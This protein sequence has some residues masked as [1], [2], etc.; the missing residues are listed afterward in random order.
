M[1]TVDLAVKHGLGIL[2]RKKKKVVVDECKEL[3]NLRTKVKELC[4]YIMDKKVKTRFEELKTLS[5]DI[6]NCNCSKLEIPN[7]T[8]VAG[9]YRMLQSLLRNKHLLENAQ[10]SNAK[11]LGEL[12]QYALTED[13]WVAVAQ[14]ECV[15]KK[16]TTLNMNMQSDIPG[17]Y[18][19]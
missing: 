8:R 16:M 15:L 7:A 3:T 18:N 17:K 5:N 9:F 14:I 1:H 10:K 19:V 11:S 12:P 6:W 2:V 13:E 4:A